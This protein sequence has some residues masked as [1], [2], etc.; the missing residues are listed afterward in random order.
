MLYRV[1]PWVGMPGSTR[2]WQYA[3]VAAAVAVVGAFVVREWQAGRG[4]N[5][6]SLPVGIG[7]AAMAYMFLLHRG[8]G[9]REVI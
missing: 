1:T 2:S 4:V 3:Y 5:L 6:A 7:L 8:L 9:A